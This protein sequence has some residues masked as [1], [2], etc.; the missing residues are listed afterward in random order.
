MP[1]DAQDFRYKP[2]RYND[3][4]IR[5]D[6]SGRVAA[7][8]VPSQERL[9]PVLSYRMHF[10]RALD[11]MLVLASAV[12]VLPLIVVFALLVARDGHSPFYTQMRVGL[13]GR[14]FRIWKLRTMVPNA[15]AALQA[16]LDH[17]PALRAEWEAT[18]KLKRDPRVTRVGRFLRKTSL[19]EL[20]QLW[21]VLNGTMSL[22]GPRPMMP[23]QQSLYP[24]ESYY[25]LR[26]GISGFW[27][28]SDRN[29]CSFRDRAIFDDAY[30][31]Q[32]SLATDLLVLLRTVW[33]VLRGTGH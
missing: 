33:V 22:I 23:Q 20:P 19:D 5:E 17:N 31:R 21:N 25:R 4:L 15:E 26:P 32:I 6:T 30:D 12:F 29:R 8:C 11:V 28:V 9:L 3:V 1:Y 7:G 10:K 2:F 24:G 16:Y 13:N 18:Q 27:Q 14:H